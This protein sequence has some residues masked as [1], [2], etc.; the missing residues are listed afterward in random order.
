MMR[1]AVLLVAVLAISV[2]ALSCS[3]SE[4]NPSASPTSPG[5]APV[6]SPTLPTD[7]DA[8]DFDTVTGNLDS[9]RM[10]VPVGWV[11]EE[12]VL[13]GG[14]SRFYVLWSGEDRLAQVS[15]NCLAGAS[16]EQMV[17]L[18]RAVL[19]S[20]RGGFP[21]SGRRAEVTGQRADIYTL[22]TALGGAQLYQRVAYFDTDECGWRIGLSA[23]SED[24]FSAYTP[25]FN[26]MLETFEALPFDTS[27]LGPQNP[28]LPEVSP[29][30]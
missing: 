18:D 13:P 25:V 21:P 8:L 14:F 26:K 15:V 6:P 11:P 1:H 20:I 7:P 24:V 27:Q 23:F 2:L 28:L 4:A 12:S 29:E 17:Q 5:S 9:Y 16:R 19:T 30:P 10:D 3:G 22:V